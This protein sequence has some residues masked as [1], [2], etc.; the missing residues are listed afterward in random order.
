MWLR[1][2]KILAAVALV[3]LLAGAAVWGERVHSRRTARALRA[4]A[5]EAERG[6]KFDQA[7]RA[8]ARYLA[9]RPEDKDAFAAHAALLERL[10]KTSRDWLKVFDDYERVVRTDPRKLGVRRRLAE[11]ALG[12]GRYR[13]AEN[14]LA[15]LCESSPDDSALEF[16]RGRCRE[17]TGDVPGAA[18]WYEKARAHDPGRLDAS[19]RLS[20][21]LR[22]KLADPERAD[23]VIDAMV[24]ANSRSSQAWLLRA[25]Y[26]GLLHL[27][28]KETDLERALALAPGDAEVMIERARF[29]RE[30]GDFD[31]ARPLLVRA[32]QADPDDPRTYAE[33]AEVEVGS[34]R[35][36]GAV[37]RL[38][39]RLGDVKIR[40]RRRACRHGLIQV[41]QCEVEPAEGRVDHPSGVE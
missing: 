41:G 18:A 34:G 35:I 22:N 26:R 29:L 4:E 9:L 38:K 21:L 32:Q 23:R 20:S 10:A 8:L 33:L 12:L 39:V 7:E 3:G 6:Q 37:V 13:D 14:H 11:I 31:H 16:L 19:V 24:A 28:G 27:P 40:Q 2:R 17:G 25:R 30:S 5:A 36:G 15:V 1:D